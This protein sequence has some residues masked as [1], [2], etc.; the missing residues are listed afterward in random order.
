MGGEIDTLHRNG[1]CDFVYWFLQ[2]ECAD[3]G[4][5][6]AQAA[7]VARSDQLRSNPLPRNPS[8]AGKGERSKGKCRICK[9]KLSANREHPLAGQSGDAQQYFWSAAAAIRGALDLWPGA[10]NLR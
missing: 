7:H 8:G 2:R 1:G 9:N 10:A 3:S 5:V 6:A 4:I